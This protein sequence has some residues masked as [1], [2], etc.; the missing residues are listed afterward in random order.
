ME[1]NGTEW[2]DMCTCVPH[3]FKQEVLMLCKL[4]DNR[5]EIPAF[6]ACS[7]RGLSPSEWLILIQIWHI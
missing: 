1:W 4:I 7:W 5:L 2:I 3:C 6:D